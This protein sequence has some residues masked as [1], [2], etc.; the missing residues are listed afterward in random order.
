MDNDRL[1]AQI[2]QREDASVDKV[3]SHKIKSSP[4]IARMQRADELR[5][6]TIKVEGFK[7]IALC[8]LKLQE[9]FDLLQKKKAL[10]FEYGENLELFLKTNEFEVLTRWVEGITLFDANKKIFLKK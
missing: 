1:I 10:P 8:K 5:R 2:S 6:K 3:A 9:S 4:I 7:Q